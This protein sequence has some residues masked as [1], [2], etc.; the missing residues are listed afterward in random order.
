MLNY[1]FCKDG[2]IVVYNLFNIIRLY[3]I[4]H[5]LINAF[6]GHTNLRFA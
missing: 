1:S 3:L 5:A 6:P 2:I 4:V